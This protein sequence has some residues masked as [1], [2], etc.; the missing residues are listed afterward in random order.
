[1]IEFS[2]CPKPLPLSGSIGQGTVTESVMVSGR[3][4]VRTLELLAV[5]VP[6]AA[7]SLG[8]RKVVLAGL[9]GGKTEQ[10]QSNPSAQLFAKK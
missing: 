6:E 1:M 5:W 9:A 2:L 10:I 7:R 4:K 3:V 8:R